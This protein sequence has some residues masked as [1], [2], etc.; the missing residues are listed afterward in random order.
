MYVILEEKEGSCSD[1]LMDEAANR[2]GVLFTT[3]KRLEEKKGSERFYKIIR[4][5]K[6]RFNETY[7]KMIVEED[8]L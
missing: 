5:T 2:D 3:A 1:F 4:G 7:T 8:R 6:Y